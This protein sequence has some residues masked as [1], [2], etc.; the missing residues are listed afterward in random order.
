MNELVETVNAQMHK[1]S[2][3]FRKNKLS[4]HPLKTKYIL[5]TNSQ[6][7]RN[8]NIQLF[9][10]NNDVRA[11]NPE[12]MFEINRS[13][14]EPIRF[15]GLMIDPDLKY[16]SHVNKIKNKVSSGLYFMRKAKNNLSKRG[17]KSL[18]YSLIHSHIIYGIQVWTTCATGMI[19]NIFKLQ[20]RAIRLIHNAPYNAHTESL[21]KES[22]ILPLPKLIEFF[23]LQ[24]MQQFTNSFL[25][26]S[27]NGLWLTRDALRQLESQGAPRYQL[28]NDDDIYLPPSRLVS[29]QKAPFYHFP[30]LWQAFD[31]Y[32][33]K[34]LRNKLEFNTRL[35][36]HYLSELKT[37]YRCTRLLCP[38][39]H[40]N[41]SVNSD[42]SN[43][44]DHD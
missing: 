31:N 11:S 28:R 42:S 14:N 43:A 24:F 6:V 41:I 19:N 22:R 38:F 16:T 20:K 2:C 40:L 17:M 18:Y 9:I 15:L 32:D 12:K 44:S 7:V 39:C 5:F 25:P 37:D 13:T 26:S 34:I 8:S 10:D 1:I 3:Y 35:K 30:R 36:D 4:L 23:Q 27:F 33:I 29:T 21:F